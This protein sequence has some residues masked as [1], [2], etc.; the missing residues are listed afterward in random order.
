MVLGPAQHCGLPVDCWEPI[1]V[2]GGGEK[3]MDILTEVDW[4]TSLPMSETAQEPMIV[5]LTG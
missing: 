5:T 3:E 4:I 1:D 2:Q